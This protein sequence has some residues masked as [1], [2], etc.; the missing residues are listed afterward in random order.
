MQVQDIMT[1]DVVAAPSRMNAAEAAERCGVGTVALC[2][3]SPM[4]IG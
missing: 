4:A 2:R 3:L 1:R